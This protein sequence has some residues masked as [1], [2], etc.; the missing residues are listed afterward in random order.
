MVEIA[1][2]INPGNKIIRSLSMGSGVDIQELAQALAEAENQPR[3]DLVTKKKDATSAS[4]SAYGVFKSSISNVKASF[5]A[6]KD[7]DSLLGKNIDSSSESNIGVKLTSEK[8]A[9]AGS[10]DIK[11]HILAKAQLNEMNQNGGAAFTSLTQVLNGGT[12]F[13]FIIQGSPYNTGTQSTVLVS[14]PTPQGV[15]DA[16]NDSGF[17]GTRAYA[18][19]KS[20][21]GTAVSIIVEGK[22]G[23]NNSFNIS[24]LDANS[25][26]S[27]NSG[28]TWANK[29]ISSADLKL[30]VNG[31]DFVYREKNTV[32]DLVVGAELNFKKVDASNTFKVNVS[33]NISSFRD[34]VD[35]FIEDE[36]ELAG[37]LASD[38]SAVNFVLARARSIID[39][40]SSTSTASFSNLRQLGLGMKFG[41]ELEL[42]DKIFTSATTSSFSD[43]RKMLTADTNDQSIYSAA[44][45][46]LALDA[47]IL[48]DGLINISGT[49]TN[50][51]STANEALENYEDDLIVL[52]ERLL[53]SQKRYLTQFSAMESIV[54]RSK[55]T[56]DYLTQ[57]FKAMQNNNNN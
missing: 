14:N 54:Q 22:T 17:F 57:Q 25:G 24:N 15:I 8:I 1:S 49:I 27:I 46:G 34:K 45:K 16:I 12:A 11:V 37:S 13:N 30:S 10:T 44:S 23:A 55:S 48:L 50:R 47:S 39:M 19:N 9:A 43:I 5:D 33:E 52:Q 51:V 26:N 3:I 4:I 32:T 35:L 18:L 56:G 38:K 42:N 41:G 6:M 29:R 7:K 31:Q 2:S 53:A 21:S 20:S 28:G 40:N 36:D